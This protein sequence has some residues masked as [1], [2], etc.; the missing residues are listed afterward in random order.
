MRLR[1]PIFPFPTTKRGLA[2]ASLVVLSLGALYACLPDDPAWGPRFDYAPDPEASVIEATVV[3]SAT[4][5]A[6]AGDASDAEAGDAD[7]DAADAADAD[8]DAA[9]ADG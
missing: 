2:A 9:D 3:D 4:D 8:L 6:D 5:A 1:S 7:P